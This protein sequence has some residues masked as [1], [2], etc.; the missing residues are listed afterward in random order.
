M[1]KFL[2]GLFAPQ[3][4]KDRYITLYIKPKACGEV[5]KVR[6]D[7]MNELSQQDDGTYYV[8]KLA[9]GERC[10]FVVELELVFSPKR[11]LLKKTIQNG[12]ETT[13]EAYEAF[14]SSKKKA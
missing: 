14:I 1:L 3:P 6:V 2:Q 10:P 12:E 7:S 11:A 5:L 13:R 8:R 9:R 4:M